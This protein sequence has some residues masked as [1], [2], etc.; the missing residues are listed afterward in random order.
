[1]LKVMKKSNPS[2]PAHPPSLM[3]LTKAELIKRLESLPCAPL[4]SIKTCPAEHLKVDLGTHQVELETQNQELRRSR[5]LVEEARDRYFDLYDFAP[6][7][8]VTLDRH[9]MVHEIN[10]TGAEMLGCDRAQVMNQALLRWLH[11]ESHSKFYQHLRHAC[12]STRR[13]IDEMLLLESTGA[14]R[15]ISMVSR[16]ITTGNP[17]GEACRTAL[18][19]I[20]ELKRKED[21]LTQSRQKL[22]NLS[23]HLDRTREYERRHLAREIHDELGQ[24]LASL[25]F[26]AVMLS[27]GMDAS[28]ANVP[29]TAAS[30][31]K[32]IDDTIESVRSIA[33]DLRPAVLDLGLTAAIEWQIQDFNRR[34]RIDCALS[35]NQAEIEIDNDRATAI[36]RIVQE[37]LTNIQRH[38]N[39]R[40]IEVEMGQHSDCLHIRI[41]DNGIGMPDDALQKARTFGI[42]GMRERVRLLD[43]EMIISSLPGQGTQLKFNIPLKERRQNG[44]TRKATDN[45]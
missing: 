14:T 30:L 26:E 17:A 4:Y 40:K 27:A 5:Q 28:Q 16:A 19:D 11:Q 37:S 7:G 45:T 32:Q 15:H 36:F 42:E 31:L 33:A 9:G 20:S 35:I 39:A 10:L 25:R 2:A 38:A 12:E 29:S 8:Y 22:R 6:V 34:T 23:A 3:V 13:V 43:G 44:C 18:V 24:K 21:E 1:M 41:A